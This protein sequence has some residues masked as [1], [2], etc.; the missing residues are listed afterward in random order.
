MPACSRSFHSVSLK[1]LRRVSLPAVEP[2]ASW[3]SGA[4]SRTFSTPRPVPV[5]IQSSCG[6]ALSAVK[7]SNANA[8]SRFTMV[9]LYASIPPCLCG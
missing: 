4:A 5:R 8:R 1:T 6:T 7:S 9:S 2:K 3:N